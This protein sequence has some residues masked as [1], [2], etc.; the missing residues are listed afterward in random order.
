MVRRRGASSLRRVHI[1][2]LHERG[3]PITAL[4]SIGRQ[5]WHEFVVGRSVQR[6]IRSHSAS[7]PRARKLDRDC[8][9]KA[10]R[11]G[12]VIDSSPPHSNP[13]NSVGRIVNGCT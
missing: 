2:H 3:G 13:I 4:K 8:I 9:E 5:I 7:M 6:S 1:A 12:R 11:C 10:G